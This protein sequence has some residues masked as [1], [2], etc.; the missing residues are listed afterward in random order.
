MKSRRPFPLPPKKRYSEKFVATTL[1]CAA[2]S[3]TAQTVMTKPVAQSEA[4]TDLPEVLIEGTQDKIY[5]PDRVQTPKYTQPLRDIPQ[6]ITV[7]PQTVI[8]ER[9]ATSLSDVL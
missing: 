8:Q 7:V 3:L 5:K 1:L 6:T 4:T 9:G 2:G